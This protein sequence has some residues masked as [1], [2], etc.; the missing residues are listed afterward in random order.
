MEEEAKNSSNGRTVK[1]LLLI[2]ALGGCAA[3]CVWLGVEYYVKKRLDSQLAK[4]QLAVEP[5]SFHELQAKYRTT[6][7]GEDAAGYYTKGL[8][9]IASNN[10]ADIDKAAA[11][12]RHHMAAGSAE[13]L[14]EDFQKQVASNLS[15][16]R[17]LSAQFD[18]AGKLPL[19]TFDMGARYG[20]DISGKRMKHIQTAVNLLSLRTLRLSLGGHGN[21]AAESVISLLKFG[22]IFDREPMIVLYSQKDILTKIAC[23]NIALL[24][25]YSK[26]SK[27]VLVRLDEALAEL[28]PDDMVERTI[29]GERVRQIEIVRNIFTK[30]AA[31]QYL[32]SNS[33][34]LPERIG[35]SRRPWVRIHVRWAAGNSFCEMA[36][37]IEVARLP[38][39]KQFDAIEAK[40]GDEKGRMGKPM[41]G[42]VRLVGKD[43]ALADSSRLAIAISRYH[44]STGE[45]PKTL[46]ELVG[47]YIE[48]IP[49]DPFTGKTLLYQQD[50]QS[51]IVYSTGVDRT[52]DGGKVELL[53]V[54]KP[55]ADCG[56]R[57]TVSE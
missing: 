9:A 26:P 53:E 27:E 29:I 42:I 55:P 14:P 43:T 30:E 1:I 4:I 35:L 31:R 7:A 12:Y 10:F 25:Q 16:V 57:F 37:A 51:Y 36:D 3:I 15:A 2:A 46:Q 49:M 21:A 28:V 17:T 48:S 20:R 33:P 23:N 54:G 18:K 6:I 44:L 41:V 47:E 24:L 56:I 32:S 34:V 50:G 45:L 40:F 22:R 38:W 11:L 19:S 13:E 39:P 52:D 5:L 8:I